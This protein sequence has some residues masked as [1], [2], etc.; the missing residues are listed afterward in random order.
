VR[1]DREGKRKTR[2][3]TREKGEKNIIFFH[4]LSKFFSL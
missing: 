1:I 2:E 4:H 3:K